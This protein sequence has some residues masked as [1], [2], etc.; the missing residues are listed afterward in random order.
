MMMSATHPAR[1]T[2][3]VLAALIGMLPV[4]D[5]LAQTRVPNFNS[6]SV[7]R[8]P[9]GGGDGVFPRR[10]RPGFGSGLGIVIDPG[11]FM[12]PPQ[13]LPPPPSGGR[14]VIV[15]EEEVAPPRRV[16]QPRPER[17]RQ[18]PPPHVAQPAPTPRSPVII[19]AASEQRL[20]ATA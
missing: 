17:P 5:A 15:E 3:A 18:P 9:T 6:N 14:R 20:A 11:L 7:Y 1:L 13:G 19:P 4:A 2:A 12:P 10:P 16:R 8:P